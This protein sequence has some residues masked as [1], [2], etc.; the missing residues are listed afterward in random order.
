M[1]PDT[2]KASI[3]RDINTLASQH[4]NASRI[5]DIRNY[6]QLII[7]GMEAIKGDDADDEQQKDI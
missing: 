7:E 3:I 1:N 6:C 2:L 5:I 4:G